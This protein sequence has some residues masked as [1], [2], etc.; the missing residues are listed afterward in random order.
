MMTGAEI[1]LWAVFLAGI[2]S[3]GIG[4]IWYSQSVF[5]K[6]WMKLSG[7]QACKNMTRSYIIGFLASLVMAYIFA[8]FIFFMGV[9]TAAA[10]AA[11][12]F[13][14]WLGFFATTGLGIVLWENKP[15]KLYLINTIYSLVSL[16]VMGI[17]LANW[18]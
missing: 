9:N 12:G 16:V 3:V 14:I 13:W 17:I 7:N 5:G 15:F 4:A 10:G 18:I 1:N 8:S 2:V 6:V 11:A